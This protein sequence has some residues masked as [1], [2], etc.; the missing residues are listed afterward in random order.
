MAECSGSSEAAGYGKVT[1]NGN[2]HRKAEQQEPRSRRTWSLDSRSTN[3]EPGPLC[4]VAS[5]THVSLSS[6][7]AIA[8]EHVSSDIGRIAGQ[9]PSTDPSTNCGVPHTSLPPNPALSLAED[10]TTT[11]KKKKKKKSKKSTKPKGEPNVKPLAD[12]DESGPLVLRISRNKHWRYISSYHVCPPHLASLFSRVM[13]RIGPMASAPDRAP[14]VSP[15]PKSRSRN[16]P[17]R[18]AHST[19]ATSQTTT[20]LFSHARSWIRKSRGLLPARLSPTRARILIVSATACSP[21]RQTN[22]TTD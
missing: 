12:D 21:A 11:A 3:H 10:T 15:R 16:I 4:A 22:S 20:S 17:A 5:S 9:A 1:R 6:M 19:N 13:K 7:A 2:L 14:R 8:I 18:T